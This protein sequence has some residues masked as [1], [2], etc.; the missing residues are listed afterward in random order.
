MM[1][2]EKGCHNYMVEIG[3][4]IAFDGLNPEDK[5]W[6]IGIEKPIDNNTS[7]EQSVQ[8]IINLHGHGGLATSGNYR[9]YHIVNGKKYAHTIDPLT[10]YPIQT[11]VLSA[12][13]IA[14][15]CMLADGLATA[16]MTVGSKG[17]KELMRYYPEA[18]YMLIVSDKGSFKTIMSPRFKTLIAN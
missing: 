11:D 18:S 5:P 1:L 7:L 3:G 9:N 6:R 4:E 16:C 17:V 13:I 12:T 14:P 8:L 2:Q 10:G 15:S